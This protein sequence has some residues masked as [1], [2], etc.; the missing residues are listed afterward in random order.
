[1]SEADQKRTAV[2]VRG[3]IKLPT[4]SKDDGAGT[5][6]TDGLFDFIASKEARHRVE[7]TGY[8]GAAFRS[9]P[10]EAIPVERL[11]LRFWRGIPGAELLAA[12]RRVQR[13][14]AV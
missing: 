8:A 14:D 4:A 12:H 3:M 6:G 9:S 1:M 13:R 2:A 11:P 5:G 7:V 10:D